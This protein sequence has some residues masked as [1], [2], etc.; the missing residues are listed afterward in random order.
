M[1][2]IWPGGGDAQKEEV[3]LLTM[4]VG[5]VCYAREGQAFESQR[6]LCQIAVLTPKHSVNLGLGVPK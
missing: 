6:Y 2:R 3:N 4:E 5:A 1:V